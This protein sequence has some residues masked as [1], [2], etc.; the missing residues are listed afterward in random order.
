M[1][2]RHSM[3]IKVLLEQKKLNKSRFNP[4][5]STNLTT[6]SVC[7]PKTLKRSESSSTLRKKG[8]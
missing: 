4:E 3:E 5:S 6:H 8:L 1:K 2:N 7:H